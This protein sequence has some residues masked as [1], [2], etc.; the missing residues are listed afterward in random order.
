MTHIDEISHVSDKDGENLRV[1]HAELSDQSDS[2]PSLDLHG[3]TKEN[4][5]AEMMTFISHQIFTGEPCCRIV[6]GKGT[7][8]LERTVRKEIEKL[9]REYKVQSSF[10]SQRHSDAAIVVVF[11]EER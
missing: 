6:H 5:T 3:F 7:G 2:I 1:M 8:I 9:V 11:P 10:P 4:A